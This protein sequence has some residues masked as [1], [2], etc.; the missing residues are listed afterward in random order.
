MEV[1]LILLESV[2]GLGEIGEMV[3][4]KPGHA[5]NYLVP[6]GLAAAVS[7][8]TLRQLEAK[9][10]RLTDE[11]DGQLTEA[12]ALAEEIARKSVTIPVQATD[13]EKLYGSVSTHQIAEA[14]EAMDLVVDRRKIALSE[15][16]RQL[17]VYSVDVH[18]H[19]EVS[20]TLKVWVVKA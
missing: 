4:V 18:L 12:K 16:I 1:E 8:A 13:D 5:R 19:P 6:R 2:E 10:R 7:P 3:K 14:L 15:P 17:G 20:A 11:Y 9:K